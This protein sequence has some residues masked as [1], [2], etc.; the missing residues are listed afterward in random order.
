MDEARNARDAPVLL[1]V[2][3]DKYHNLNEELDFLVR[4]T[5]AF[6]VVVPFIPNAIQ[7]ILKSYQPSKYCSLK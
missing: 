6:Y 2:K 3:L 7:H 4:Q 1:A 5:N